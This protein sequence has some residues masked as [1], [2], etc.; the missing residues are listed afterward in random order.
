MPSLCLKNSKG[1]PT[2]P[3][4]LLLLDLLASLIL[5]A[6]SAILNDF[7]VKSVPRQEECVWTRRHV[8]VNQ[9]TLAGSWPI[10]IN[11]CSHI[12]DPMHAHA[13]APSGGAEVPGTPIAHFAPES[14]SGTS[15][16]R[17]NNA[18]LSSAGRAGSCFWEW[19]RQNLQVSQC[20]QLASLPIDED[21]HAYAA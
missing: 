10:P 15:L 19:K 9:V 7:N 4:V 6:E 12:Q 14:H 18:R 5:F 11:Y 16:Q 17:L 20:H 13:L 2:K 21:G 1:C 8:D 3:G